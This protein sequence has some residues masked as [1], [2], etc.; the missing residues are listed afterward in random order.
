VPV[1]VITDSAAALD[2]SLADRY[3]VVTVPMQL[4][5]GGVPVDEADVRLDELVK[6]LE[7]GIQTSGP[8]PGAFAEALESHAGAEG[9]VILTVGENLSSTYQSAVSA[10][11]MTSDPSRVRVVDTGTAAGGEGLVVLAAAEAAQAGASLGEVEAR[12]SE[13]SERVRLVAAVEELTELVR[14]GRVPAVAARAGNRL[15]VRP[16]FEL[17]REHIRPLRPAFSSDGAIDQIL[18]HWRRSRVDGAPLHVAVL[19]ALRED[20]AQI[21]LAKVR[22]EVEPV[23][24]FVGT[25][26]P[27]MVAH[28]GPG[29]IGLAWWWG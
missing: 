3:G 4:E 15:G 6:H 19:H 11:T 9:A 24:A 17:R 23:T 7:E 28:T 18:G 29:V 14:G 1:V 13:V 21:L 25:F 12:A 16:L 20:D 26:G 22:A 10:A 8:P 27:V 2:Q 5:I